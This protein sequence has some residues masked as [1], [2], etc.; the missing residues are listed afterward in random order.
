[1]ARASLLNMAFMLAT[2]ADPEMMPHLA[3]SHLG[4]LCKSSY[5]IHRTLGIK[6]LI[7]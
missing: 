7:Y 5:P 1:M 4:L 6:R 2:S 3:A